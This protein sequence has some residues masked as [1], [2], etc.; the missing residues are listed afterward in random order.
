MTIEI[1]Q[2]KA[3]DINDVRKLID[4]VMEGEFSKEKAAYAYNDLD[5]PSI[6]YGGERETFLVAEEDGIIVGT[7]AIKQDGPDT[8]LL[9]R[10]FVRREY[11][12][13]GYGE[14]LLSKAMEFC[15]ANN[16]KNVTFRGTDRMQNALKLCLKNGF[17]RETVAD[18]GDFN[19][20]ALSKKL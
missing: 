19:L 14:R 3:E 2:I 5:D 18:L 20:V 9:R 6:H 7:V 11:R 15:F 10:I 17:E 1:R 12:G 13:K 8:A 16:Y 4:D